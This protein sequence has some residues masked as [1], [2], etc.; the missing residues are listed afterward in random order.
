MAKLLGTELWALQANA[1]NAAYWV[2]ALELQKPRGLS[3]LVAEVDDARADWKAQNSNQS[4]A[5]RHQWIIDAPLP[6]LTSAI[7][8]ALRLSTSTFSIRRVHHPVDFAGYHFE[9]GERIVCVTRSVHL[10]EDIHP[11]ATEFVTERYMKR[12]SKFSKDGKVVPNHSMPFG[13]GVSMCE[14]R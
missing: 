8:E 3:A 13:G 4:D 14:G 5:N 11:K 12:Q 2:L 7:Q 10:D 9:T 1:V 6:L